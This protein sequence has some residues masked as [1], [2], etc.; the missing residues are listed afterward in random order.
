M[1]HA[2]RAAA[3]AVPARLHE[4]GVICVK[5]RI[6]FSPGPNTPFEIDEF[7]VLRPEPDQVLVRVLAAGI[8]GSDVHM[9]RGELGMLTALPCASGHEMIGEIVELGERRKRDTLGRELREGD[10]VAY[11][12]FRVCD[13]CPTCAAGSVACPNRYAV[14]APLTVYD[15]PHFHGAFGDYYVLREGQWIYKLPEAT[16]TE[17]AVPANCAIAQ[18]LAG[19]HAG[20]IRFGDTVVVQGLGGL[21]IYAAALARDSGAGLVIGI[22]MVPER[23]ELARRFGAHETID[24]SQLTSPEERIAEIQR[25]TGGA[26]ADVVIEMAGVPAVVPEGIQSMRAGGRYVLIG[27]TM[28]DRAT[29]VV[30]QQIVR[31][32]RTLVG[33]VN[34]EQW[35]LPRTLDWLARR[36]DELPFDDLVSQV[37][38]LEQINDAITASDW[39]GSKANLGR[40]LISMTA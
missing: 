15:P 19:V 34:Y 28:A 14:R 9:Y 27:N 5:G 8:C 17:H 25:L 3:E 37:Y 36:R 32:N 33:I 31:S 40:A 24:I 38:P 10:R 4:L 30:P 39:A 20:Q 21:G 6:A 35:M 29:E 7:P 16:K 11:A 2:A 23:L 12:Y 22:D 1:I 18:A 13:G 26:G